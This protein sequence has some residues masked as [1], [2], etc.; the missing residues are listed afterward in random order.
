MTEIGAWRELP[1]LR[2]P[3][4]VLRPRTAAESPA[5]MTLRSV[6]LVTRFVQ[7]LWSV[8]KFTCSGL[9][10]SRGSIVE[11]FAGACSGVALVFRQ[12]RSMSASERGPSSC[13][14]QE[15]EAAGLCPCRVNDLGGGGRPC[16]QCDLNAL[17]GEAQRLRAGFRGVCTTGRLGVLW[18]GTSGSA[19]SAGFAG[20]GRRLGTSLVSEGVRRVGLW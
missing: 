3:F 12:V 5:R 1:C 8:H 9:N 17:P 11:Q 4:T 14:G 6:G 15:T 13:S 20:A 16:A 18:P 19:L 7:G 10:A 2:G